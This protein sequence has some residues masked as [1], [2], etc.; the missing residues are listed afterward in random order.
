MLNTNL[1][2]ETE[3]M[4]TTESKAPPEVCTMT[5]AFPVV[6]DD[7]A[8]DVK[9]KIGNLLVDMPDVMIDFRIR[10]MPKHG[11]PMV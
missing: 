7:A 6:S 4:D 8:I 2:T 1:K 3:I 9:K 10:R 5:I 11:P